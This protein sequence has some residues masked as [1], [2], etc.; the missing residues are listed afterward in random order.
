MINRG[1][2]HLNDMIVSFWM[3]PDIGGASDD[4]VGTDPALELAY[5]YN[6]NNSDPIYGSMPPAVGVVLLKGPVTALGDSIPAAAAVKFIN[7]TDPASSAETYNYMRGLNANGTPFIDPTTSTAKTFVLDGD[8]VQ[9]TGWLDSNPADVR[10]MLSTGTFSLGPGETQEVVFA[11]VLGQGANRLASISALKANV[12]QLKN[13][14]APPPPPPPT[15]NCPRPVAYWATQC[16]PSSGELTP[17]QLQS[18]AA[19][20][21][22][23]SLFFDWPSGSES[24]A[25]C[26]ATNPP[27]PVDPRSLAKTEYAAL[28]AN[29]AAG[30]L[31]IVSPG[32]QPIRLLN[33][34]GV[35]CPGIAA[36]TLAQ[37]VQTATQQAWIDADYLDDNPAHRRALTGVNWGGAAFFGGADFG[38]NFWGGSLDP[39]AFP[40]SFPTVEIRFSQAATQKAYRFLRLEDATGAAPN[41]GREY[42]YGGFHEVPF[43]VWDT[44]HGVQLDVAFVERTVTDFG[45]TIQPPGAQVA[46]FD[47][48]W[49]PDASSTGGREFLFLLNT[50]Y[51]GTPKAPF[52]VDDAMDVVPMPILYAMW[53]AKRSASDVIDDGDRMQFLSEPYSG[54]GVDAQ[55][56]NLEA[57]PLSDPAVQLAYNQIIQCLRD[58]NT[59]VTIEN[60]CD[61]PTAVL[62]SLLSAEANGDRVSI[63]WY[64]PANALGVTIERR[65]ASGGWAAV[66]EMYA[67]AA[68]MI[69][70]DDTDIVPGGRYAY[71][72]AFL[73]GGVLTNSAE[74]SVVV[75]A[76]LLLALSGFVPN[77]ARGHAI[78]EFVLPAKARATL[79][80]LDLQGRRVAVR[81]VAHLGPGRATVSLEASETPGPGVYV[82]RLQ[83]GGVTA[84]RKAVVVR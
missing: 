47:S 74:T 68:G 43:Q 21:G 69:R 80:V 17:A 4:L 7:G 10:M 29:W 59:G 62:L 58:I 46:T 35:S 44:E 50:P 16:P 13:G 45:G 36:T 18:V 23:Q 61:Q 14:I 73:D 12:N 84:S 54:P 19:L 70:F 55:F 9:G 49:A 48:T 78:V 2:Q 77:P 42:R 75:P 52:T 51:S 67:D 72:L 1:A 57:K 83:Q 34:M 20:T 15:T 22:A 25:F 28:M 41:G 60:P 63:T 53:V 26:S 82:I 27:G 64:T 56:L 66:A 37:L 5:A 24:T 33:T 40:D 6:A 76:R 38:W 3:D 39:A 71:R 32:G 11:I 8:P 31:G 79:E 81:E 30:Q 65:E